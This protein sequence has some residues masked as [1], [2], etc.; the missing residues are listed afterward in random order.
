[1]FSG[2]EDNLI[3]SLAVPVK[4]TFIE[5][6]V[7]IE[8]IR[9]TLVKGSIADYNTN[10]TL[11]A[12]IEIVDLETNKVIKTVKSNAETGKFIIPLPSG[13]NYSMTVKMNDYMFH[14]ENFNVKESTSYAEIMKEI[15]LQPISEGSK[16]ILKNTFFESGK[17]IITE[18]SY[19]ELNRFIPI[20][21]QYPDMVIEISGHTDN[22]GSKSINQKLSAAR[23]KAVV[24]YLISNGVNPKNLK[25]VGYDFQFL[26]FL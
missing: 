14:S 23:A 6:E 17:S 25:A 20:F 13:K 22:T 19:T 18:E 2:N 26:D 12:E 7:E 24:E 11:E 4:E 1:M 5:K 21:E 3:A 9:L 15:S 8:K 16:I 10:T